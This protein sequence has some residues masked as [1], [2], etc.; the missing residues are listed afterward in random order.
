MD[1]KAISTCPFA[2]VFLT[3]LLDFLLQ[4]GLIAL[5]ILYYLWE[6][7]ANQPA[8]NAFLAF[9]VIYCLGTYLPHII[10]LG[11][12]YKGHNNLR[13]KP[14]LELSF[15]MLFQAHYLYIILGPS[16]NG[17]LTHTLKEGMLISYTARSIL[18]ALVQ[19]T[20]ITLIAIN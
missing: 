14:H 10:G 13:R 7:F 8:K 20:M 11:A 9:L 1:T 16:L 17:S 6:G 15:W 18:Q 12:T 3:C 2:L 19:V 4:N 5:Y